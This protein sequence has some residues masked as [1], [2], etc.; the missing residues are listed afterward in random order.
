MNA[1]SEFTRAQHPCTAVAASVATDSG[2]TGA[3]DGSAA[4]AHPVPPKPD[5]LLPKTPSAGASSERIEVDAR[6]W[7]IEVH[8]VVGVEHACTD[9]ADALSERRSQHAELGETAVPVYACNPA[10][11]GLPDH[12]AASRENA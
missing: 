10:S 8:E 7:H 1:E 2:A 9:D 3:E 6:R 5:P 4:R 12:A 11:G